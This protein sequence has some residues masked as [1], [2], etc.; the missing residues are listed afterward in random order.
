MRALPPIYTSYATSTVSDVP[1]ANL[2]YQLR[3]APTGNWRH[4]LSRNW[5]RRGQTLTSMEECPDRGLEAL[6][7]EFTGSNEQRWRFF[8][9]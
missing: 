4:R 7:E 1:T 8:D 3:N 6:T 5:I 9:G 2:R